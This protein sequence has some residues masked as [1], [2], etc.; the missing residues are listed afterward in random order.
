MPVKHPDPFAYSTDGLS[1]QVNPYVAA[2]RA[3]NEDGSLPLAFGRGLE[4]GA[5]HWRQRVAQHNGLAKSYE[6]LV[7]EIGC[8]LGKTLIEMAEANPDTLF[9]GFDITFKR[10]VTTA[11]RAKAKGL[12]NVFVILANAA[13][14]GQIFAPGEIDGILIF[15]PDPWV[16]KARQAKNRLVDAEFCVRLNGVLSPEGFCW[17]KT[18]QKPYFDATAAFLTEAGFEHQSTPW[19]NALLRDYISTFETRFKS[20]NLDTYGGWWVPSDNGRTH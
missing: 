6:R 18:D 4:G 1:D 19:P 12:T 3:A 13:S 16:K 5:G 15:F 20:K 17:F 7:V 10:V 14:I 9:I 8:H 11:Q 2:L